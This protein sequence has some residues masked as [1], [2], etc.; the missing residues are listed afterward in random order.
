M[1]NTCNNCDEEPI[2]YTG[3]TRREC[4]SCSS[5]LCANPTCWY[6]NEDFENGV[7][8]VYHGATPYFWCVSCYNEKTCIQKMEECTMD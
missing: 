1:S 2:Y 7:A 5:P 6:V 4:G 3:K 8:G